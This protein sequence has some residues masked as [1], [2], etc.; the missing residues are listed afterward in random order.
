[1]GA[2][3]GFS[4]LLRGF[5]G[6]QWS[7]VIKIGCSW[8]VAPILSGLVSCIMYIIVDLTVLRKKDPINAGM[9]ALPFIYFVCLAFNAFTIVYGGSKS[10][11][12]FLYR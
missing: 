11:S 4:L 6:I 9:K 12:P 5:D 7:E 3:L 8:I 1:M 2:T 10:E